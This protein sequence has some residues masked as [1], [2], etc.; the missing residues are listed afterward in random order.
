M[1]ITVLLIE[2]DA[3]C[4][5]YFAEVLHNAG[6]QVKVVKSPQHSEIASLPDA[7]LLITDIV[8]PHASGFDILLEMERKG[9]K[10]PTIAI[11]ADRGM[12]S[13]ITKIRRGQL[14]DIGLCKPVS[15][16]DLLAA[17][18]SSLAPK[19]NDED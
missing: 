12:V 15:K 2:D 4:I 13:M 18:D 16:A 7:D 14:A 6:Y 5:S 11:S 8:M 1:A 9:I 19:L 10:I 17:V 3:T